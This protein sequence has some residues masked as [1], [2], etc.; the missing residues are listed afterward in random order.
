MQ[1]SSSTGGLTDRLVSMHMYV[2]VSKTDMTILQMRLVRVVTPMLDIQLN[3]PQGPVALILPITLTH[4]LT[5]SHTHSHTRSLTL[6]C[7]SSVR[8][9]LPPVEN[10]D[11]RRDG[12]KAASQF[13]RRR[14]YRKSRPISLILSHL[15]SSLIGPA[16]SN[17][18]VPRTAQSG[19]ATYSNDSATLCD[20]LFN[21]NIHQRKR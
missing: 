8:G 9:F 1:H 7:R 15:I 16:Q 10:E 18:S 5:H 2:R 14:R 11:C 19:S 17:L 4:S 12:G 20:L 3:S 13:P 6:T 21:L